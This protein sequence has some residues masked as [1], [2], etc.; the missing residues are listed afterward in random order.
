MILTVVIKFHILSDALGFYKGLHDHLGLWRL[1]TQLCL[2]DQ[3]MVE[4]A[5]HRQAG[6]PSERNM[7]VSTPNATV[8]W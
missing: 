7:A 6:T 2:S 3:V 1:S 5:A 4:F 8:A